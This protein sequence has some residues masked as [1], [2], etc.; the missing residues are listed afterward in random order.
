[1]RKKFP[2]L[3]FLPNLLLPLLE[4]CSEKGWLYTGRTLVEVCR[5]LLS[6]WAAGNSWWK[7]KSD[8][9]RCQTNGQ[10]QEGIQAPKLL[11]I[12]VKGCGLH[13]FRWQVLYLLFS[14]KVNTPK[15]KNL[16]IFTK[17]NKSVYFQELWENWAAVQE[18]ESWWEW[19]KCQGQT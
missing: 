17:V 14:F 11:L 15:L 18:G 5:S 16:L 10:V 1:M 2:S 7:T 12:S 13:F 9:K 4:D 19:L 3:G 6:L 8:G